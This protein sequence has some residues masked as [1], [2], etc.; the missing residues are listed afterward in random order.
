M[1]RQQEPV[2]IHFPPPPVYVQLPPGVEQ[3]ISLIQENHN[4]QVAIYQQQHD[5]AR[6]MK[7]LSNALER[8]VDDRHDQLRAI[9][10]RLD[11]LT[12]ALQVQA[13][14]DSSD[15]EP[16]AMTFPMPGHPVVPTMDFDVPPVIPTPLPML[17]PRRIR[18]RRRR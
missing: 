3:L 11:Y 16:P 18:S 6:D 7:Q 9:H 10:A 4:S 5:F 1:Q 8:G 14:Q 17:R 12:G 2:H 15:S 13:S